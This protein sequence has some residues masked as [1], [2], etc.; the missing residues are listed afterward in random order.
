ML[1]LLLVAAVF[2]LARELGLLIRFQGRFR[3]SAAGVF[4]GALTRP[5][6]LTTAACVAG[7]EVRGQPSLIR[8]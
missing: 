8:F 7:E 5:H 6:L 4:W 1:R 2:L 3:N